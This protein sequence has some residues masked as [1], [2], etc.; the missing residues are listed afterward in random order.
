MVPT[1]FPAR[2]IEDPKHDQSRPGEH[3]PALHVRCYC[4]PELFSEP[5]ERITHSSLCAFLQTGSVDPK[6]LQW[7][8]IASFVSVRFYSE[9]MP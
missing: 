8:I 1:V 6:K 3:P 5:L 9:L 2:R 4:S 7:I